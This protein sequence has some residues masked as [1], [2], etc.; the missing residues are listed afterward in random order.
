MF[1][2]LCE[3]GLPKVI[4]VDLKGTN[5]SAKLGKQ[6]CKMGVPG[7][8]NHHQPSSPLTVRQ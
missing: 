5:L 1:A 4:V 3:M 2:D 7:C 8:M 6:H